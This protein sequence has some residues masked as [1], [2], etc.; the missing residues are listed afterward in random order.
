MKIAAGSLD[1]TLTILTET[2]AKSALGQA[3]SAYTE[4]SKTYA[5]RLEMRTVDAARAGGRDVYAMARYLIRF[6]DGLTTAHRIVVDGITYSILS[7]EPM[8]RRE[9]L[10]LTLEEIGS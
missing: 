2:A 3:V 6:R 9:A 4:L 5:Q 8:G 10:I 1:R 7:I